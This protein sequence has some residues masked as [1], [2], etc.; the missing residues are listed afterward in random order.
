MEQLITTGAL[1]DAL[2]VGRIAECITDAPLMWKHVTRVD[3]G[4]FWCDE[5][6]R[7][8]CRI[9]F[10][11]EFFNFQ[12]KVLPKYVTA[13]EAVAA[14]DAG[15]EVISYHGGYAVVT[16]KRDGGKL[17]SGDNYEDE[18][19]SLSTGRLFN[20]KWAIKGDN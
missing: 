17:V 6:G 19:V 12:W 15:K 8:I 14:L 18:T 10:D 11:G 7:T 16:Y 2:P 13:A 3:R 20:G 4:L 5:N 9:V 1:I